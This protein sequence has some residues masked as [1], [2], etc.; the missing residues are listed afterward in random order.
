VAVEEDDLVMSCEFRRQGRSVIRI[1]GS[2]VTRSLLREIG[3]LLVDIHGQSEH[4]SLF[5][6]KH[7]MDYLDAFAHCQNER[8]RFGE[9]AARLYSLQEEMNKL[10]QA[11]AERAHRQEIL[12]YQDYEIIRAK[13]KEG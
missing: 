8:A 4:L 5:D 9:S 10:K 11:V 3:G 2:A 1:N 6:K 7:H 12:H 13:L